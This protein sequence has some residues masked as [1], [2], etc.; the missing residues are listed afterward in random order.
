MTYEEIT[1]AS[2]EEL[3]AR[4]EEVETR[5]FRLEMADRLVGEEYKKW[6]ELSNEKLWLIGEIR[7]RT[8]ANQA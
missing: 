1:K 8:Q 2:L 5:L 7:N 6:R 3:K 4:K